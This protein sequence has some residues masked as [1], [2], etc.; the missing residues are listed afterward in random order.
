MKLKIKSNLLAILFF[1]PVLAFT[2][3]LPAMP[4]LAA[5]TNANSGLVPCGNNDAANVQTSTQAFYGGDTCRLGD[6]FKLIAR[7]VNFAIGAAGIYSVLR[8]LMGA[9]RLIASSGS[10]EQI[11]SGRETIQNAVIGLLVV[12][13]AYAVVNTI[14]VVFGPKVG[15]NSNGFLYNPFQ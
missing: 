9:V 12:F 3:F 1:V 6:I 15:V 14:F 7:V 11:K 10:E 13:I 5:S 2:L 4:S 8:I